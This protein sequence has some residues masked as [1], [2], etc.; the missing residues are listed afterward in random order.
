MSASIGFIGAGKMAE[1]L[2]GGLLARKV[3]GSDEI[4]ACAPSESTRA[5]VAE[6]YGIGMYR[7]AKEVCEMSDI[8]VL[9]VKPKHV[10][11]VFVAG[12][13]ARGYGRKVSDMA[14]V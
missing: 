6:G 8:V 9:A 5:R 13:I 11:E 1:A 2:I 4:V 14:S 7:T 10:P 12:N 3:F